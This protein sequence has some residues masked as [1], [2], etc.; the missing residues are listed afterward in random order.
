MTHL[1]FHNLYIIHTSEASV[2]PSPVGDELHDLL[3]GAAR[4]WHVAQGHHLP[5][6]DPE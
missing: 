1:D 5:Q 6:Q 2:S 3:V 4:V